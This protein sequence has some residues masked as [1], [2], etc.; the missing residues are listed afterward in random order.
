[1]VQ[2]SAVIVPSALLAAL[3]LGALAHRSVGGSV[4]TAS[5][6]ESVLALVSTGFAATACCARRW[7]DAASGA[8]AAVVLCWSTASTFVPGP[9]SWWWS[10]WATDPWVVIVVASSVAWWACADR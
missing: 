6:V 2:R 7:P 10:L 9:G 8:G 4:V 5:G 3:L 1:L